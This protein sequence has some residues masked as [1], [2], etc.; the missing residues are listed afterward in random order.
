[1]ALTTTAATDTGRRPARVLVVD[2][3]PAVRRGL[4][5]AINRTGDLTV[6]GEAATIAEAN[7]AVRQER[8]DA[9]I[10]DL[11][12]GN[13]SGLELIKD[14]VTRHPGLPIL[15]LSMHDETLYAERALRAGAKGY[16]MKDEALEDILGALRQV[17]SGRY[18][19]TPRMSGRLLAQFAGGDVQGR[20]AA[21]IV[22][23]LT[24]REL[25]VFELIGRGHSTQDVAASLHLSTKT[26]Y[27]HCD[28]IKR[29]LGLTSALELHQRAFQWVE[30]ERADAGR[31][32]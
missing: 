2:D 20:P 7:A 26:V 22:D 11:T 9:V 14:L 17:L 1:M 16:I 5:E 8:P 28:N 19:L 31:S 24:D 30:Q 4:T 13:E 15:V 10:A 23:A 27:T 6:C 32:S 3:H 21:S 12:L 29:K 25:E 18:Y